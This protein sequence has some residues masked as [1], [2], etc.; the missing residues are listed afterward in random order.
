M[1]LNSLITTY[2]FNVILELVMVEI[3]NSKIILK[4]I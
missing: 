3:T 1:N 2:K 4:F